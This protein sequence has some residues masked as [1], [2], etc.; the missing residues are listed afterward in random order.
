M[1]FAD[2]FT[3][4]VRPLLKHPHS[5]NVVETLDAMGVLLTIDV[6]PEDMGIIIGKA[7]E[8]AKALRLVTRI[9]GA[10]Q[11]AKVSVKINEPEGSLY[12]PK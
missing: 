2:Y 6:H 4:V 3:S 8:T 9:F 7:G 10:T 12:K 11:R 5:L 1:P